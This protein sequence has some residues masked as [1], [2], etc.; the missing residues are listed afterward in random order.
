MTTSIRIS[1]LFLFFVL[2]SINASAQCTQ[3][4]S[5]LPAA[6]ELLGFNLGMT[7]EQVKALVPQT[8]FGRNDD[9]GVSKTTINPFFDPTIDKTRFP[10]VR[11]VSLD[12]LDERLVSIWIGFD[13][14][15]KI[16]AVNEFAKAISESL[17]VPN[18]WAAGR[19]RG[20]QLRC[21]GFQLIVTTVAGGPSLR[22]LDV[23]A[24]DT[25]AA[26]RQEKEE[27]DVAAETAAQNG[28]TE[29]VRVTADRKTKTYY[30][31][32]CESAKDVSV[33]N[34]LIFKNAD[35]AQKAGFKLAKGCQ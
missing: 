32:A 4:I 31:A 28:E 5:D 23:Q 14:T 18:T 34:R 15:Y 25:I 24:D 12:F 26:R 19:G 11:S 3:K 21:D 33:D 6:P 8:N 20:Q 30:P 16:Q 13:E 27:R 35:E 10:S 22:L 17:H 7:K 9:F 2:L 29:D 1:S